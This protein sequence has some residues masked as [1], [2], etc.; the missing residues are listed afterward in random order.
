MML[1][2]YVA[3]FALLVSGL[4][5]AQNTLVPAGVSRYQATAFP[6]RIVLT[7][8]QTPAHSQFINW[9]TN[10][11]VVL[12][13]LELTEAVDGPGLHQTAVRFEGKTQALQTDNGLAHHHQVLVTGLQPDTLYAYRV[14][15]QHTWSE[16]LQ[17]RT[18]HADFVPFQFIYFG[19]AQNALKSHFSRV[20]RAALLQAPNA[21]LMLHAGD[22]VNS[23]Y[24]ILDNEWG[25]WFDAS[26]WQARMINQLVTTGNHEYVQLDPASDSRT[27]VPQFPAQFSVPGNGPAPLQDTVFY[28]DYQGVRFISLNS[29]EALMNEAMA[30]LQAEWLE[31]VLQQNQARWTVVTYHHP[32]F[33][34][35]KGR[36]NERLRHYWQ[37]L[38]ARYGVD[39]VL[40]GHDHVYGRNVSEGKNAQQAGTVYLVSVAGP[41]M[42]LVSDDAKR[43]MQPVAEDTQLFQVISVEENQLHYQALTATGRLYDAFS[44]LRQADG[45]KVLQPGSSLV[46]PR[47]CENP[48][49][50]TREAG[51]CWQGDAFGAGE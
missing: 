12:A 37:P 1:R 36:D 6:D 49:Q 22:L 2:Q 10:H 43:Q 34:V 41:K 40:Q 44:L 48:D 30:R 26:G 9:R 35:S 50:A 8:T 7:P 45:S 21:S 15:G 24:G 47:F 17:F 51:R 11:A 25:E 33:S 20:A 4:V 19:D 28:V 38:F 31:Q 16:W 23:R 13:E 3:V 14:R 27:L 39:L 46:A 32:M 42:Y 18:A 5:Q 29:T